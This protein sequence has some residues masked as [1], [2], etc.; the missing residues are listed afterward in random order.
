MIEPEL[1]SGYRLDFPMAME[2]GNRM[3]L[4]RSRTI[5][6]WKIFVPHMLRRCCARKS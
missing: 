3:V 5:L 6:P 2:D 4:A 1:C